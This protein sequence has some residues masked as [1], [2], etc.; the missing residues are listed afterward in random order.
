MC[1]TEQRDIYIVPQLIT[2][3]LFNTYL[4]YLIYTMGLSNYVHCINSCYYRED[5]QDKVIIHPLTGTL[6]FRMYSSVYT[7]KYL[8]HTNPNKHGNPENIRISFFGPKQEY[9]SNKKCPKIVRSGDTVKT[10]FVQLHV[11]FRRYLVFGVQ[12]I[13]F[14]GVKPITNLKKYSAY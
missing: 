5:S 2:A 7:S 10:I 12:L 11:Y 9:K 8:K 6:R 13:E 14:S 1:G 4:K 3:H